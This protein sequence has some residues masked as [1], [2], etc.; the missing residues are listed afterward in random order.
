V[1]GKADRVLFVNFVTQVSPLCDCYGHT[2][3][4]I[5]PDQGILVSRD[6]VAIDQAGAD[7]VNR[8]EALPGTALVTNLKAGEDKFRGLHPE[9]DWEVSLEHGEK[10]GLGSRKYRLETLKPKGRDW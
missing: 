6:P 2:D 4:P 9:I 7:L 10:V 3:A 8:A 1:N 5:V